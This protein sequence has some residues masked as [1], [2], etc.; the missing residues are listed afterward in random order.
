MKKKLL[1]FVGLL[2]TINISAQTYRFIYELEFRND[3][4]STSSKKEKMVLDITDQKTKFYDYN[5]IK[6]DS[7][8]KNTGS[9]IQTSSLTKQLLTRNSNSN[10]NEQYSTFNFDY[11]VMKSDD[12]IDWEILPNTK[13]ISD[14]T[15]QKAICSF[16]G[17]NWTAWFTTSIP[18]NEGPYKF[19]G[20][21]GLIINLQDTKGNYIYNLIK[22]QIIKE[23]YDTTSFLE[24]RYG[25]NPIP[26]NLSQYQ[27]LMLDNYGDPVAG[28][29]LAIKNGGTVV[30]N[31]QKIQ[32]S[33]ELDVMRKSI[34]ERMKKNYNPIEL[35]HAVVYK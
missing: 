13:K 12:A 10:T 22:S 27:K 15:V 6:Y 1:L 11:F 26:I 21:P 17:R 3:S 31:N 28:Y 19:R 35:N 2:F 29:R 16:G 18:F 5:F 20:L 8:N 33:E 4:T 34:K 23:N 32:T 30:I 14:F 24:T 25:K 9:N 7:I